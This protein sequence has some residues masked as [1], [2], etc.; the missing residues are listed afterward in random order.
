MLFARCRLAA[1]GATCITR[2]TSLRC[3]AKAADVE[4]MFNTEVSAYTVAATGKTLYRVH[5]TQNLQFPMHLADKL[6]FVT[7]VFDFPTKRMRLGSGLKA[8]GPSTTG[9]KLQTDYFITLESLWSLYGTNAVKGS[10]K[11]TTGPAE[12][13]ADSAIVDSVC[14]CV[15]AVRASN[16]RSTT[17]GCECAHVQGCICLTLVCPR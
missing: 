1:N 14:A 8:H 13:Q 10:D 5:P 12:F 7:N 3:S 16:I 15:V 11:S 4:K 2:P 6:K 17:V 9:R